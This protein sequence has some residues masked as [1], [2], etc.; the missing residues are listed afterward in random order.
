LKYG[1]SFIGGE[2]WDEDRA[3]EAAGA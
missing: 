3:E 1:N 2:E